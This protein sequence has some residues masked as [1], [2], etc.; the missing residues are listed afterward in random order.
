M[1]IVLPLIMLVYGGCCSSYCIYKLKIYIRKTRLMRKQKQLAKK[2]GL[3]HFSADESSAGIVNEGF[4]NVPDNESE[5]QPLNQDKYKHYVSENKLLHELEDSTSGQ[6]Q[7]NSNPPPEYLQTN[8]S[9]QIAPT[10]S[11][12]VDCLSSN[13]S[14]GLPNATDDVD[15]KIEEIRAAMDSVLILNTD[16]TRISGDIQS[17][18][19][20]TLQKSS[21]SSSVATSHQAPSLKIKQQSIK[22]IGL[23]SNEQK[24]TQSKT[25]TRQQSLKSRQSLISAKREATAAKTKHSK[26]EL[27][28]MTTTTKMPQDNVNYKT[29][30]Q[31][32]GVIIVDRSR[33]IVSVKNEKHSKERSV[34]GRKNQNKTSIIRQHQGAKRTESMIETSGE[35]L[36][37]SK[38]IYEMDVDQQEM[39]LTNNEEIKKFSNRSIIIP[40]RRSSGVKSGKSTMAETNKY[41]IYT[42]RD[43]KKKVDLATSDKDKLVKVKSNPTESTIQYHFPLSKRSSAESGIFEQEDTK[44]KQVNHKPDD[45]PVNG[46][47]SCPIMRRKKVKQKVFSCS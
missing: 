22:V 1:Y 6:S 24:T 32:S 12:D 40:D 5:N 34:E 37:V 15:S 13:M 18:C 36:T 45:V 25:A 35:V 9:H 38:Q 44:P 33:Y 41:S 43:E 46:E 14:V 39:V 27:I 28:E 47:N 30:G 21:V 10:N 20:T 2:Q 7:E 16:K 4:E 19:V 26:K 29:S 42:D 11:S 3:E 8:V 23:S 31:Q 17:T